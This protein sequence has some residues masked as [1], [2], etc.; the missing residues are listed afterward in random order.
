MRSF[1]A[2]LRFLTVL[3]LP[4]LEDDE[5][6]RLR[7]APLFFPVVGLLIGLTVA[8]LDFGLRHFFPSLLSSVFVVIALAAVSGGLHLDGLA[9]TADG[10]LSSRP[11]EQIL[12]IM[13]DSRTGP[14]GAAAIAGIL[15]LKVAAVTSVAADIRWAAIVLMPVAGRSSLTV[16]LSVLPY[17]RKGGGLAEVFQEDRSAFHAVWPAVFLISTGWIIAQSSGLQMAAASLAGTL[18]FATYTYRKIGGI[19]G[20][21]LGAACEIVEALPAL[22]AAISIRGV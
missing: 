8:A 9:D 17:A 3:P 20:D 4:T 13:R 14:M 5:R 22:V 11:R 15:I 21:T 6:E 19:T 12:E 10:F 7:R 2:A 16:L 18:V 1:L